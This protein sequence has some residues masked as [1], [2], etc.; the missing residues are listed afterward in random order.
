M[1][2]PQPSLKRSTRVKNPPKRYDDFISL[3]ALI[4]NDGEPSF[5]Q[6]AMS[7]AKWKIEMN[8]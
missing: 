3:V 6:E 1:E 2:I 8:K 7:N 4:S 5:Y